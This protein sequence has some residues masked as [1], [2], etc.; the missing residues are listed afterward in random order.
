MLYIVKYRDYTMVDTQN[1]SKHE[2]LNQN[3]RLI[4]SKKPSPMKKEFKS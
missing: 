2:L 1:Q 4:F 3:H